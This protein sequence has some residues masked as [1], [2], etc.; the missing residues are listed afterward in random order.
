MSA[1]NRQQKRAIPHLVKAADRRFMRDM[2]AGVVALSPDHPALVQ[3]RQFQRQCDCSPVTEANRQH[4]LRQ[5]NAATNT[6][7]RVVQA[8]K[9]AYAKNIFVRVQRAEH[10]AH[11]SQQRTLD[12]LTLDTSQPVA[13]CVHTSV[14]VA[15]P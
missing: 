8:D 7:G 9:I 14:Q 4:R 13:V 3:W 5:L 12:T 10:K 1:P 2:G 6:L 15:A 11:T